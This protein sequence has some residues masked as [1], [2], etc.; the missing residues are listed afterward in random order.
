MKAILVHSYGEPEVLT[1]SQLPNPVAG[2]GEVVVRVS[3]TSIN[4]FDMLRRAGIVKADAP[5][6]FPGVIGIDVAGTVVALGDGVTTLQVGDRV[7]GMADQTYAELCV[8]PAAA[9]AR[10]PDGMDLIET[11]A[12]P[13]VVTTGNM[14]GTAT[15]IADGQTAL[16]T[17]AVGNVGR[18][19][20]YTLKQLGAHVIAAVLKSQLAEAGSLG[21]DRVIATDDAEALAALPA[22]DA[23]ADTVGHATAETLIAKV[24]PGGT[25][26]TVL[27]APANAGTYPAV[28]VAAVYAVA[29]PE[30]LLAMAEAVQTGALVIP[31]ASRMPLAEAAAAHRQ[32]AEGKIHG[33]VLL[34]ADPGDPLRDEAET[35]IKA[36]LASYNKALNNA[37]TEAVLPLYTADG[38]FMAPFS[39][40]SIG[41]AAIREAYNRVFQQLK[42]NVLFSVL[43][44][45]TLTAEYAYARTGSAGH[46]TSSTTG[47]VNSEGNQELFVFRKDADGQ[48]KIARY[49]FS[50]VSP[51]QASGETRDAA[52]GRA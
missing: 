28:R 41:Q 23:V 49:S 38:I 18:A 31:V 17:G 45:V 37:D 42:F 20:V 7:F 33:K 44:L 30:I 51:L 26:A 52:P 25:F 36:L 9:L 40:S 21:A 34:V 11:A 5:I 48:W 4:P 24:K 32:I 6:H 19:A 10:V 22:L 43:E 35:A 1:P 16:V 3:A 8:T 46:T 15:G 2:T 14:L 47:T 13:V 12:L 50:P 39:P 29:N 27:G